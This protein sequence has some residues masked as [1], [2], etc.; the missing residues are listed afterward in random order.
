MRDQVERQSGASSFPNLLSPGKIG[1]ATL[2]NRTVM[3]SMH[4]RF[5][6][7]DRPLAREIAFY[8]ARVDGGIGAITS[9][10]FSP[11]PE[12][13]FEDGSVIMNRDTDLGYQ[14]ELTREVTR[15]GVPFFAQL[16]HAGRYAEFDGCVA[17]SAIRAPIKVHTP[18]ALTTR[19]VERTIEDFVTAAEVAAEGGYSGIELMGSEGYMINQF[20]APRTNLRD[21]AFGG[22][23]NRRKRL[24]VD[25]V[26]LTRDR[27]GRDFPILFRI[28]IAELVENGMT[29]AEIHDLARTLEEAGVDA[30]TS[31]IGWH[32]SRIPTVAQITPRAAFAS[33]TAALKAQVSI[34][35]IAS[36]RINDPDVAEQILAS[37]EA[38]FV[39]LARQML[40]DPAF[41]A[42]AGSGR[43]DRINTC[44]ACNQACLDHI[45][46]KTPPSCLV[47]PRAGREIDFRDRPTDAPKRVAVLGGGVAGLTAAAEAAELGH[48]VTLYES[49]DQLGGLLHLAKVVPG[50]AEF[51][52][53]IRYLVNRVEDAGVTVHLSR[54]LQADE[55]D[56]YDDIIDA[57]GVIPRAIDVPGSD[58]PN[59]VGYDDILSG[60][61]IAGER[62]VIIGAGGIGIDTAEYLVHSG[63]PW[64]KRADY[65]ATYGITDDAA[66]RG[67][68]DPD[69]AKPPKAARQVTILQRSP[70]RLGKSLS[71]TTDWIKRKRLMWAETQV[72]SGVTYIRFDDDGLH[73]EI[74]GQTRCLDADTFVI[75]AGQTSNQGI[76]DTNTPGAAAIHSIGGAR[77]AAELDAKRAVEEATL[78]AQRL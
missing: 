58:R 46:V 44:I 3:G 31:G 67:S 78:L 8:R 47:N 53:Y 65:A 72:L 57:T 29:R 61:H 34:P 21:D 43:A 48:E 26:R 20:L 64:I 30:F 10:G 33:E 73:V 25:I 74:E 9:G 42:K 71:I 28:S 75:C 77:H 54:K 66:T 12:G 55:L 36:N 22:D 45:F 18:R 39:S 16:L 27:M 24:A 19:E 41:V 69:T 37:G 17:P 56:K 50:K 59:V 11:N 63:G 35:V 4:T 76:S 32:E 51:G 23:W 62:V 70:G 5:E 49:S 52:E 7:M 40:A 2:R 13:C 6:T 38:D 68:F 60:R 1:S 15:D 14:R